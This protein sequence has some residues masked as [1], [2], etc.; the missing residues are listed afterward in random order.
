MKRFAYFIILLLVVSSCNRNGSGNENRS[1]N[2]R[3]LIIGS[4]GMVEGHELYI[5]SVR[6]D[7]YETIDTH[8]N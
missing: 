7:H 8:T 5:R 1:G 6:S 3:T 2:Q 4:L